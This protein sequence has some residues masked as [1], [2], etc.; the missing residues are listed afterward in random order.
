MNPVHKIFIYTP[1][2]IIVSRTGSASSRSE[3]AVSLIVTPPPEPGTK[4]LSPILATVMLFA[5][6]VFSANHSFI[7][8]IGSH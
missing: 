8:L 6:T 5:C 1:S 4:G 3:G 7:M 2:Y